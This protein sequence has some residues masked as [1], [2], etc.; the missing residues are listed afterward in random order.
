ME[1]TVKDVKKVEDLIHLALLPQEKELLS[2]VIGELMTSQQFCLRNV[3][4][5]A[6]ERAK[7]PASTPA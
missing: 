4:Q 2:A 3:L 6:E 5:A 1:T 7:A